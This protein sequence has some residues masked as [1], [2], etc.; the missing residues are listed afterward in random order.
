VI[1]VAHDYKFEL[2]ALRVVLAQQ[3][4]Y[5]GLLG[6]RRRG[7]AILEFLA[8][9]GFDAASLARVHVPVGLDIGAR[10]AA[11]IALAALAEAVAV[12]TGRP[13]TPLRAAA[14]APSA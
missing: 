3:P 12:R 11:E 1:L 5:I 8:A 4:A 14:G 9:D 2:P 7:R 10:S 6:S 13:G